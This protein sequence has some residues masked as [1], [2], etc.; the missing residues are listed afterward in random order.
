MC[1]TV[2]QSCVWLRGGS[3]GRRVD[4]SHLTFTT[5]HPVLFPILFVYSN[6]YCA[7]SVLP[8]YLTPPVSSH[9]SYRSRLVRFV[10]FSQS[11]CNYRWRSYPSLALLKLIHFL[12][13]ERAPLC[14]RTDFAACS[15]ERLEA[16]R[17]SKFN[18]V[19]RRSTVNESD[20]TGRLYLCRRL[21]WLPPRP[22]APSAS[23]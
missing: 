3:R 23:S 18:D 1:S 13:K 6:I 11:V 16:A 4:V 12:I 5:C 15:I 10:V 17:R 7:P 14:M 8:K 9:L 19:T 20:V 21:D 22:A 2:R